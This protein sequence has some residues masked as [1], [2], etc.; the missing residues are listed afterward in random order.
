MLENTR[1]LPFGR[2]KGTQPADILAKYAISLPLEAVV[3]DTPQTVVLAGAHISFIAYIDPLL[4]FFFLINYVGRCVP[5]GPCT[6]HPFTLGC[7]TKGPAE[8]TDL[9]WGGVST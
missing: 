3:P 6:T 5:M 8:C 9:Q 7:H 2:R 1:G 4:I